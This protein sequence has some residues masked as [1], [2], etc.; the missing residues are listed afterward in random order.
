ME[1]WFDRESSGSYNHF[2]TRPAAASET[3]EPRPVVILVTGRTA[4]ARVGGISAIR[5]HVATAARLGL[6][7]IVVYPPR[8][9]AL[10]AEIDAD[11]DGRAVC[12]SADAAG[13][14]LARDEVEA[15]V[16]AADWFVSPAALYAFGRQTQGAAVARFMDRGR[17][18]APV[19]R[20]PVSRLRPLFSTLS[21]A[22]VSELIN[23]AVPENAQ[24]VE[25]DPGERHRLSDS[26][27]IERCERK[28][29]GLGSHRAEPWG[30]QMFERHLA[31]PIASY[32]ACTPVT[33]FQVSAVKIFL[34][35]VTAYVVARPSYT[36]G[37][38]AATLYLVSRVLDAVAGD[39]ARAAVKPKAR[40]DKFDVIGD[41]VAHLCIIWAVAAR[42]AWATNQI[43]AALVTTLGLLA[44]GV[45]TY[46]RV[47][48]PVWAADALGIRHRVRR[49][50]FATRFSRGNGP[51]YAFLV[52]ALVGRLDLFLWGTAVASHLF[53]LLWHRHTSKG[54][55]A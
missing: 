25:M 32:L 52:S 3:L 26:A 37:V 18:V 4:V 30:V 17:V 1:R 9:T 46:R 41:L 13:A 55:R 38:A 15:L 50:N 47:L 14:R 44:S 34:G 20:I 12:V 22:P 39:L 33:P 31:I 36:S 6:T 8:L 40:G 16:I 19:A 7:P 2:V 48:K 35:L 11:L 42:A 45:M 23:D 49:D 43:V 5:R 51:A 28:L 54:S 24:V 21:D 53:Y 10:G 29:F 27:A